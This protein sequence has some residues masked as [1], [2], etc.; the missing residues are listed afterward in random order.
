MKGHCCKEVLMKTVTPRWRQC[1]NKGTVL[2][3]KKLYCGLHD[4]K[5]IKERQDKLDEKRKK[6]N[7]LKRKLN[8]AYLAAK[9]R[10]KNEMLNTQNKRIH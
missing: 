9:S 8:L 4:P 5:K 1:K 3:N 2:R 7:E 10:R 6:Q